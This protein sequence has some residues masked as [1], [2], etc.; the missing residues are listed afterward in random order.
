MVND[1]DKYKD[2]GILLEKTSSVIWSQ[3]VILMAEREPDLLNSVYKDIS[4]KLV[5]HPVRNWNVSWSQICV[6]QGGG[7]RWAVAH[8]G[9]QRH[10]TQ[11]WLGIKSDS[12]PDAPLP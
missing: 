6:R 1:M 4:E 12:L 8:Q 5:V 9:G 11:I 2:N 10:Q 7:R 3:E